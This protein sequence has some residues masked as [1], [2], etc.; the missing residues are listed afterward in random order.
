MRTIV[1]LI[2][3]F[4][5]RNFFLFFITSIMILLSSI[6][7]IFQAEAGQAFFSIINQISFQKNI[8]TNIDKDNK[9]TNFKSFISNLLKARSIDDAVKILVESRNLLYIFLS[10]IFIICLF[11]LYQLFFY[12]QNCFSG[13]LGLEVSLEYLRKTFNKLLFLPSIFYKG[14]G[15][16]G[17]LISR[18]TND[19]QNIRVYSLYILITLFSTP[20]LVIFSVF[21]LLKKSLKF[22]LVI[23]GFGLIAFLIINIISK[24][25]K[26]FATI[27]M[28]KIS[29]T[30]DYI[31]K[32]IYGIDIIKIFN[33]NQKEKENFDRE[34]KEYKKS[35]INRFFLEFSV[36]PLT[37][38]I[39]ASILIFV[40]LVGAYLIWQ[41]RMSIEK[42]FGF[43]IYL[44]ILSPKANELS[45]LLSNIK[46]LEASIE[47][48][49]EILLLE[50]EDIHFGKKELKKFE[51]EIEFKNVSFS[52][53]KFYSKQNLINKNISN[54]TTI[55]FP[56]Q[57]KNVSFKIN[58]NEFVAI[59]GPS[60][61]GKSTIVN[62]ISSL[63]YPTSGEILFDGVNYQEYTLE[64]IRYHISYVTQET[65]LFPDT[66]YNN[67]AF[68]INNTNMDEVI[69]YSKIA[70]AYDFIMKLPDKYN[71]VIG[72]RGAKLSGGEK[73]RIAIA[74]ALIKKPK[75]LIFDEATSNLDNESENFITKAMENISKLQTT[76][77]IAHR[78]STILK[79]D[80]IIV[81]KEGKIVDIGKHFE[82]IERCELYKNLQQI[83][84]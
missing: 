35:F 41:G 63:I 67:I 60:G 17:D 59:V 30:T 70:F 75:V 9:Q 73:Q 42:I 19:I 26:K 31:N 45:S 84:F 18:L 14:K 22:T 72:E 83:N 47:R 24:I 69:Y 62:L 7:T 4:I 11:F 57:L 79:A 15:Q 37:E 68:G 51:G 38:L 49:E 52:Y 50:N 76:I 77:V 12:L 21:M 34:L 71:T 64:S 5:K 1:K 65:I 61:S 53:D 56:H 25:I 33:K 43:I 10:G 78:L 36:R 29:K 23:V 74:R 58:K 40:L 82:L 39:G 46:I 13:T 8:N 80:K 6:L 28:Q 16:T 2:K 48:I 44:L 54:E 27:N 55:Q 32:T 66:I 81:L 3:I 20:I